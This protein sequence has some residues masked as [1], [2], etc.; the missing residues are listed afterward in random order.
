MKRALYICLIFLFLVAPEKDWTEPSLSLPFS[1]LASLPLSPSLPLSLFLS[2]VSSDTLVS[3]RVEE[4][5]DSAMGLLEEMERRRGE[6]E[7]EEERKG[8]WSGW[9][10]K[11]LS[12]LKRKVKR[13]WSQCCI[14]FHDN[15]IYLNVV[16][17]TNIIYDK[18][19]RFTSLSY[20][21]I[22]FC[23]GII[24][25]SLK[26]IICNKCLIFILIIFNNNLNI[27]HEMKNKTK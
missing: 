15:I 16:M 2:L 26:I 13:R 5:R 24:Y 4:Q 11:N 18:Q 21:L 19:Q 17:R 10:K 12:V 3:L 22:A 27:L 25:W 8:G 9:G 14:K 23:S 1:P 7:K 20:V 6:R